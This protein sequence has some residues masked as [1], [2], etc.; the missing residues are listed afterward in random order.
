MPLEIDS[1]RPTVLVRMKVKGRA[2]VHTWEQTFTSQGS[3]GPSS[4]ISVAR[5]ITLGQVKLEQ[6]RALVPLVL[7]RQSSNTCIP[8]IVF[9]P[10]SWLRETRLLPWKHALNRSQFQLKCIPPF[11]YYSCRANCSILSYAIRQKGIIKVLK[12]LSMRWM[13][14]GQRPLMSSS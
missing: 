12:I 9:F 10:V 1:L 13:C 4:G 2:S 6:R 7:E 8:T 14:A 5:T 3:W 11:P